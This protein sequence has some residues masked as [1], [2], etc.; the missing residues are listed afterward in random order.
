[1]R[2]QVFL[3]LRHVKP[4]SSQRRI[5]LLIPGEARGTYQRIVRSHLD[6]VVPLRGKQCR[7]GVT[8][9]AALLLTMQK[10]IGVC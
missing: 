3:Q 6:D 7:A 4:R 9:C 1:M 8:R 10:S 2:H 5:D